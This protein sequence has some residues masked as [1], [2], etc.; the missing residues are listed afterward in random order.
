MK[1]FFS[2][3]LSLCIATLFALPA[4]AQEKLVLDMSDGSQHIG[5]NRSAVY[6][7]ME[8]VDM[9]SE[10]MGKTTR[11]PIKNIERMT[12]VKEN[13]QKT[14]FVKEYFYRL[15]KGDKKRYNKH[16]PIILRTEYE[17]KDITLYSELKKREETRG[18]MTTT[19]QER[20]YYVKFDGEKAAHPIGGEVLDGNRHNDK[21]VF[22]IFSRRAFEDY[23]ELVRR[24][25]NDEF[26]IKNPI[27]LIKA[28]E[29]LKGY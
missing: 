15:V 26:S 23:P 21:S 25:N 29:R 4:S 10:P 27:A 3:C 16:H 24:I 8:Y 28:Y 12:F 22:R 1:K 9:S 5:Y 19:I 11:Y 17:G 20:W 14:K 6:S 2:L 18:L 13:G 7:T